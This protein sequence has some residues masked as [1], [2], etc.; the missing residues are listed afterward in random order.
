MIFDGHQQL[1]FIML[2]QGNI[3]PTN[4]RMALVRMSSFIC[5]RGLSE[6]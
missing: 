2:L 6:N 3:V 4:M 5:T 1:N